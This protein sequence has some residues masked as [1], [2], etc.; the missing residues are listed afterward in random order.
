MR[1]VIVTGCSG[2]LGSALGRALQGSWEVLGLD[3]NPGALSPFQ[4]IDI[5][6]R[7]KLR[8]TIKGFHSH[9]LVNA[10]AFTDVD[11]CE[12]RGE[13]SLPLQRVGL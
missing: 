7:E 3:L 11:G 10:A 5:R 6:N 12:R 9:F 2:L 13:F 1:R 8:E 4:E